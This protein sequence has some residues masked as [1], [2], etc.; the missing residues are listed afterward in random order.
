VD[1][2]P[3]PYSIVYANLASGLYHLGRGETREAVA[4]F[5]VAKSVSERSQMALPIAVAWLAAVY[6]HAGQP[7]EALSLLT[8]ADRAATYKRAQVFIN[9]PRASELIEIAQRT[10]AELFGHLDDLIAKAHRSKKESQSK[11]NNETLLGCMVDNVP[12]DLTFDEFSEHNKRIRLVLAERIVG[13][14]DTLNKAIVNVI[15][16]LLKCPDNLKQ[17]RNTAE[18]VEQALKLMARSPS[19]AAEQELAEAQSKLDAVIRECLRFN[20]VA[21]M[22]CRAC[23][24][25]TEIEGWQI[26]K[27]TLVCLLM[28]TA[29]FDQKVFPRPDDFVPDRVGNSYLTFGV[30]PHACG[31]QKV[32]ETVLR[33]VIKRL[34]L[35]KDLRRAAGPAGEL[36][37]VLGLPLPD[38][39]VVRFSL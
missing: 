8:E 37:N 30:A 5:E 1:Q 38:S 10:T 39:M 17:A 15:D 23:E 21:P 32:A 16:F 26:K 3:D 19:P 6:V 13:G 2:V 24:D 12:N 18:E 31:G 35:L 33:I 14:T 22:I 27:G 7:Q 29:M 36:K 25:D 34:L 20:P 4:A 11:A 28:K 9:V